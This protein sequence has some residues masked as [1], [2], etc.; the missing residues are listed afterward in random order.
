MAG[1][2]QMDHLPVFEELGESQVRLQFSHRENDVGREARA[3]LCEIEETREKARHAELLAE[4][5]KH[6]WSVTPGFWVGV[7]AMVAA[8]I[9]AY[10]VLVPQPQ[11]QSPSAVVVPSKQTTQPAPVPSSNSPQPLPNT[12]SSQTGPPKISH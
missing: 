12:A 5:R 1:P 4:I 11:A 8:C 6:H 2:K 7:V 3:W 10:G 9:A